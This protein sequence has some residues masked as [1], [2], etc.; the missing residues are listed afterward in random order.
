MRRTAGTTATVLAAA[1]VAATVAVPAPAGADH[2][3]GYPGPFVG[4]LTEDV[5]ATHYLYQ[6]W[7][8]WACPLILVKYRV[9]LTYEPPTDA[10]QLRVGDLVVNGSDGHAELRFEDDICTYFYIHVTALEVA[11]I[12][13]HRVG[14]CIGSGDP[15]TWPF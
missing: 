5:N 15:C 1:L 6:N 4:A 7:Y 14:V 11:D 8:G 10:L 9:N 13:R 2:P 12:N 3:V